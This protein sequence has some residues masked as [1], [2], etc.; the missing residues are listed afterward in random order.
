MTKLDNWHTEFLNAAE[1]AGRVQDTPE[2][3]QWLR[4]KA[5]LEELYFIT[6]TKEFGSVRQAP[7]RAEIDRR[8]HLLTVQYLKSIKSIVGNLRGTIDTSAAKMIR[9]SA[10]TRHTAWA[11]IALAILTAILTGINLWS[12]YDRPAVEAIVKSPPVNITIQAPAGAEAEPEKPVKST[13]R[14]P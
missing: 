1:L 4:D 7:A 13:P 11:T 14:S 12:V 10:A 6:T 5:T 8:K 2:Y 9:A 3:R